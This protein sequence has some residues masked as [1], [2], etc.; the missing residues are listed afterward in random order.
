MAHFGIRQAIPRRKYRPAS[1]AG[2]KTRPDVPLVRVRQDHGDIAAPHLRMPPPGIWSVEPQLSEP[3]H[4][5]APRDWDQ[6]G[7]GARSCRLRYLVEI[8]PR[9]HRDR[10]AKPE[11]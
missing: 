10:Q 4:Q 5:I 9:H 11:A 1:K 6:L 8:D 2:K 3:P 7:H